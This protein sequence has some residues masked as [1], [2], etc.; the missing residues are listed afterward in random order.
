MNN[1]I[2]KKDTSFHTH[3][4]TGYGG[5]VPY[6]YYKTNSGIVDGVGRMHVELYGR[7]DECDKEV[8]IAMMHCDK[9]GK[10]YKK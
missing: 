7:C 8:K 2:K 4:F 10:L 9:E 6:F 5:G 3:K 1:T